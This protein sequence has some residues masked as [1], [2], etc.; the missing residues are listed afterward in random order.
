MLEG[1]LAARHDI[2]S[3]WTR[4]RIH[5]ADLFAGPPHCRVLMLSLRAR[6][7]SPLIAAHLSF[8]TEVG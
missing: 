6:G 4:T 1:D 5:V 7:S 8:S 3:E 2:Q